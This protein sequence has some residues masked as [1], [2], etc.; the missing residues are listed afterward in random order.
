MSV[1]PLLVVEHEEDCPA[2][3]MGQWL[4]AAGV[5]LDV[6]RPYAGDVLPEHL[7]DHD[8]LMILGGT[9]GASDDETSPW[10]APTRELVRWAAQEGVPTLGVCLGHQLCALALGGAVAVNPRG[11]QLG[12][13]DVGFT[14]A[15]GADPLTA[16]LPRP[17]GGVQWNND[18]VTRLPVGAV[19]LARTPTGEVQAAR[20]APSVWGVQWHPEIGAEIVARWAEDERDEA[21]SRGVDLDAAIADIAAAEPR[22]R[23]TW[24]ELARSL[25]DLVGDRARVDR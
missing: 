10:L 24:V 19:T 4:E 3:W 7:R 16:R 17:A 12:V 8:G 2:A 23:A 6:R 14:D 5:V 11:Q 25:A 20:F 21:V 22:L 18:V 15:A 1:R 9:M 13:L